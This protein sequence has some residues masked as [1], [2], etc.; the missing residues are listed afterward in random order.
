MKTL[1]S[2]KTQVARVHTNVAFDIEVFSYKHSY[3]YFPFQMSI[4]DENIHNI[5]EFLDPV[6]SPNPNPVFFEQD[7]RGLSVTVS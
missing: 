5:N 3:S 6:C 4:S 1:K 7:K 2:S